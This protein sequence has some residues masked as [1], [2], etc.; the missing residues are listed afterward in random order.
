METRLEF[1]KNQVC[2]SLPFSPALHG[3]QS[4]GALGWWL[5]LGGPQAA[6]SRTDSRCQ[7]PPGKGTLGVGEAR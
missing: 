2:R 3:A 1:R 7:H 4:E 5:S 6:I